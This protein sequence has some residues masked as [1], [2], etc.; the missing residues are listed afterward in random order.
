M[1]QHSNKRIIIIFS[2]KLIDIVKKNTNHNKN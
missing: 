1:F 2:V